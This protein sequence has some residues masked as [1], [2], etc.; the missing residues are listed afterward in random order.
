MR[1]DAR[2]IGPEADDQSPLSEAHSSA[3]INSDESRGRTPRR[4]DDRAGT[5]S[6]PDRDPT[7]PANDSTLNTKI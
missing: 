2:P 7:M 4:Q 5:V 3:V 1:N 6:D